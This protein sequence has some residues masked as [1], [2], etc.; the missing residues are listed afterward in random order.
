MMGFEK[1]GHGAETGLAGLVTVMV[2]NGSVGE[3]FVVWF[4]LNRLDI[5][6]TG[7]CQAAEEYRSGSGGSS[8]RQQAF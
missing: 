8:K 4:A 6:D 2:G 5:I 3:V 7:K 1:F